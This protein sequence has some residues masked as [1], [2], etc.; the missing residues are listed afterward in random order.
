MEWEGL[1]QLRKKLMF[2]MPR[3][4]VNLLRSTV[5]TVAGMCRDEMKRRVT[6]RSRR[7]AKSIKAVRRRGWPNYPVSEVRGGATAPY[8]LMLEFGTSKTKK[9]PFIVPSVESLRPKL[10]EIYR[11]AFFK[12]FA[13][14]VARL[15]KA[16]K[17][18]R[19]R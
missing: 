3:E 8:M 5:H 4:S 14:R 19:P 9:Q 2:E 10:P 17:E 7:L 15:E 11:E 18:F 12:A 1:D 6:K 16:G 13:K